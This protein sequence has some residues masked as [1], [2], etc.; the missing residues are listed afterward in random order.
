MQASVGW[1]I[2]VEEPPSAGRPGRRQRFEI[3]DLHV[4]IASIVGRVFEFLEQSIEPATWPYHSRDGLDE[5]SSLEVVGQNSAVGQH[6][7]T[8]RISQ[9]PL[10]GSFH[11]VA[12]VVFA[13][14]LE[15]V[16]RLAVG[17]ARRGA[18]RRSRPIQRKVNRCTGTPDF[19]HH[20]TDLPAISPS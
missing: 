6:D 1:A 19:E 2:G 16:N 8:S 5:I 20:Q 12:L 14:V 9:L 10:T 7:A 17:S 15:C 3:S 11:H 13:A 4:D 18:S